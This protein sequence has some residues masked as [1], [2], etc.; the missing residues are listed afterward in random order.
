MSFCVTSIPL[1]LRSKRQ[2]PTTS[3]ACRAGMKRAPVHVGFL[4]A[5][6]DILFF[7]GEAEFVDDEVLKRREMHVII[8]DLIYEFE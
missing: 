2:I 7:I 5:R 4:H 8:E 6:F 1:G 3:F